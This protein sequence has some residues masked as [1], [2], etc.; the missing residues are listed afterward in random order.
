MAA[1][2]MEK[3]KTSGGLGSAMTVADVKEGHDGL[4]IRE[5]VIENFKSYDGTQHIGPFNNFTSIIGP[6]GSGKSNIMD[7][8]SFVLGIQAKH[9]RGNAIRD[10][11][12]RKEHEK[13]DEI[14]RVASV[15][16]RLK[17]DAGRIIWFKRTVNNQGQSTYKITQEEG[18][19]VKKVSQ[20]EFFEVLKGINI[21]VRARNFLVFQGDVTD[22]S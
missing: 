15:E 6:N 11:I 5:M 12:H 22:L 19:D 4:T 21:L 3:E 13:Q 16:L 2:E 9:L 8:I 10:L 14:D 20:D 17:N 18:K 7:A 1:G